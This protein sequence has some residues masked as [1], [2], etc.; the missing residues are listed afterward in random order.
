MEY[1][2]SFACSQ[3]RATWTQTTSSSYFSEEPKLREQSGKMSVTWKEVIAA[4]FKVL[5][6]NTPGKTG[7]LCGNFFQYSRWPGR[8]ENRVRL[9]Y[10]IT[11]LS[12]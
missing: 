6:Q 5:S 3:K 12:L 10:K 7:N 1:E 2:C 9:K 8:N 4:Y 11:T